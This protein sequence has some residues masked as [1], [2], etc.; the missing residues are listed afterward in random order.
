M[1]QRL[2]LD[3]SRKS[4]DLDFLLNIRKFHR[5]GLSLAATRKALRT[6][7]GE[8]M[9]ADILDDDDLDYG[10]YIDDTE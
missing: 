4:T 5:V 2:V 1:L 9:Q 3:R 10:L 6:T 8:R 7:Y